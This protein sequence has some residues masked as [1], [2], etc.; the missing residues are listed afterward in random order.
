MQRI[1]DK[2]RKRKRRKLG[3]RGKIMGTAERPR[4]TVFK[5]NRYTY[6]QAVDDESGRTLASVSNLEKELRQVQNKTGD[7]VKLGLVMGERLKEAKIDQIVFDRNG[8]LY[9]GRIKDI[10]GGIRKAGIKF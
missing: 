2:R 10:A 5:S 8:Y 3:I 4:I 6:L 9:H 1:K 7:V